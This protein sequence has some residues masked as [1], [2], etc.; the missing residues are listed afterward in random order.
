MFLSRRSWLQHLQLTQ[1]CTTQLSE[2][3]SLTYWNRR[4]AVQQ[5]VADDSLGT[6]TKYG[7]QGCPWLFFERLDMNVVAARVDAG[8][9]WDNLQVWC[10]IGSTLEAMAEDVSR[11]TIARATAEELPDYK[12]H[13]LYAGTKSVASLETSGSRVQDERWKCRR[14]YL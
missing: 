12:I 7:R 10:V 3:T 8:Y 2:V 4:A 11:P 5:Q 1:W 6:A 14:T 13:N 9:A